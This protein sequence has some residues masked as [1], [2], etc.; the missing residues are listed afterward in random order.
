[1]DRKSFVRRGLL[2]SAVVAVLAIAVPA[3]AA[4]RAAG[5]HVS[6]TII[7]SAVAS[8]S[9]AICAWQAAG[10]GAQGRFGWVIPLKFGEWDGHHRFTLRGSAE[11]PINL[12]AKPTTPPFHVSQYPWLGACGETSTPTTSWTE[13]A[14]VRSVSIRRGTRYLVVTDGDLQVQ[15][16]YA[17]PFIFPG[18]VRQ[19]LVRS[20][21]LRISSG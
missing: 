14:Q 21:R 15:A 20:F 19:G 12:S 17:P 1:M 6:G 16:F 8:E 11:Q 3:G 18:E 10:A 9:A 2:L 4:N 7:T 13:A 5:R